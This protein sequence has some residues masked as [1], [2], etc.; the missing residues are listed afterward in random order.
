MIALFGTLR[1]RLVASSAV[2]LSLVLL[3]PPAGQAVSHTGQ[4]GFHHWDPTPFSGGT[5]IREQNGSEPGAGDVP[6]TPYSLTGVPD[7]PWAYSGLDLLAFLPLEEAER[8]PLFAL[9]GQPSGSG[10]TAGFLKKRRNKRQNPRY[11]KPGFQPVGPIRIETPTETPA[12]P[13]P[14][15]GTLLLLGSGLVGLRVVKRWRKE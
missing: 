9:S 1:V 8:L 2:L 4:D 3:S 7:F 15:P 13:V 11:S 5:P 10:T 14:E 12:T 6:F